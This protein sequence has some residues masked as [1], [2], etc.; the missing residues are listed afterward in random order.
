MTTTNQSKIQDFFTPKDKKEEKEEKKEE[1]KDKIEKKEKDKKE[2]IYTDGSCSNNGSKQAKAGIGIYFGENDPRNI[3]K[4]IEG[5]QTNNTAELSA[6]IETYHIIK[7]EKEKD[8]TKEFIIATDSEYAIKCA[9]TYGEK[10]D[11]KKW[12]EEIPN[13]ELVKTLFQ[14][15]KDNQTHVSIMHIRAHTNKTDIHSLGN[16][17]ADRLANESLI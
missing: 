17:N 6:I 15:H 12:S 7:K 13:K 5:K 16:A 14:L 2:Y 3:S 11:K 4:R 10:C 8:K 9:T 1:K